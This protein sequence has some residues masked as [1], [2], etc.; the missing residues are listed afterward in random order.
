[1]AV[2]CVLAVVI[3]AA[4]IYVP[5]ML[6]SEATQQSLVPPKSVP[7]PSSTSQ[8]EMLAA[9]FRAG[10]VHDLLMAQGWQAS[11]RAADKDGVY[12]EIWSVE[13]PTDEPV[14]RDD[15]AVWVADRLGWDPQQITIVELPESPFVDTPGSA[16]DTPPM[17]R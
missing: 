2:T 13:N 6:G 5:L 4:T 1:M 10:E 12:S 7:W 11:T 3:V 16:A 17:H 8:A 15:L 9:H 14:L